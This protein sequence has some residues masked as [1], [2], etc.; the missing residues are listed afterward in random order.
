VLFTTMKKICKILNTKFN[1]QDPE[2]FIEKIRETGYKT[3]NYRFLEKVFIELPKEKF[4]EKIILKLVKFISDYKKSSISISYE[5]LY[6]SFRKNISLEEA[7]K[8]VNEYKQNKSTSKDGFIKRHGKGIGITMYEKF[9]KTSAYSSSDEWFIK[10]YGENWK[11]EKDYYMRK[12]SKRCVEYWIYRGYSLED[13]KIKVCEYQLSTSGVHKKYYKERGYSDE[14]IGVILT[15]INN[16]KKNHI[17]NT[18]YLKQKYPDSWKEI[19]LEIS[20]NYRKRM[21][22][23]GVWIEDSIIDD[24]RKY[25]SLVNRY[26]NESLLFYGELIEKLEMRS[27]HFHLDHKYSIKMGFI[28][29]IDPKIIGSVIN[30]EIIPSRIN[31]S[32]KEKCSIT[33]QQ[34]IKEYTKF[35]EKNE[36]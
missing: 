17:R 30:V 11:K 13:A 35:K 19:Y 31:S 36:S 1:I 18:K 4:D 5:P 3:N 15:H 20:K 28:N 23:L 27:K 34:L 12:K 14:E 21:E 7:K 22:E 16:K 24:F 8:V 25:K 2:K 29:D 10:K 33:K 9:Q 26:T 32:K 6:W